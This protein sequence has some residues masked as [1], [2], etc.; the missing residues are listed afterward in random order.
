MRYVDKLRGLR[1]KAV[2][3][4]AAVFYCLLLFLCLVS[5]SY[6]SVHVLHIGDWPHDVL[7]PTYGN[8]WVQTAWAPSLG[9]VPKDKLYR[10]DVIVIDILASWYATEASWKDTFDS[11][12]KRGGILVT[13]TP[14][15]VF[16]SEY[17]IIGETSLGSGEKLAVIGCSNAAYNSLGWA[18]SKHFWEELYKGS[19]SHSRFLLIQILKILTLALSV[20]LATG[21]AFRASGKSEVTRGKN[22]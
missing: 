15:D 3:L 21:V 12:V 5:Y 19:V 13:I 10:F 18:N 7:R 14:I 22:A 1:R 9:L 16:A 20:A 6:A 2:S 11:F 8:T 4:Q 17:V